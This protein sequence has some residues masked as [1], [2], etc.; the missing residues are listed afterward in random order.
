MLIQKSDL[1]VAVDKPAGWLTI[2][3]RN[4]PDSPVLC[5]WA[6]KEFGKIWV[7]HRIDRETSGVVLFARTEQAHR[8]ANAWFEKH[9]IKKAY[10]CLASGS[11]SAPFLK[12]R[13]PIA[14]AP[15]LTQVEVRERGRGGF[16]ARAIPMTGRRHQIRIHLAGAGH[17]LW[18]DSRYGGPMKI[19]ESGAFFEVS[20]VALHAS[21][22]E[23]PTGEIFE[24]PWPADFSRWV[25]C[26]RGEK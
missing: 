16:L 15:S 25:D 18:G 8:D 2:P 9:Q 10:D 3:G 5:G 22:L 13:A 24:A 7:V 21:R 26:L 1:W 23:L 20:R 19:E 4:L 14:G 12:L 11:P 6:E 17:P